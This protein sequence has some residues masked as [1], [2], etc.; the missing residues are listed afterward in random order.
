M[1]DVW[2]YVVAIYVLSLLLLINVHIWAFKKKT[3]RKILCILLMV[4]CE[5][6]ILMDCFW[7]CLEIVMAREWFVHVHEIR[8]NLMWNKHVGKYYILTLRSGDLW[9]LK[10]S[11]G[12]NVSRRMNGKACKVRKRMPIRF[13]F[14]RKMFTQ[15]ST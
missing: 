7:L 10:R 13:L 11:Y 6:F 8:Y 5:F 3:N 9:K 2:I 15:K 4:F 12:G 1:A 14:S